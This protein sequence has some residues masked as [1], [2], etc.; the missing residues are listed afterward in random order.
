[1][2]ASPSFAQSSTNPGPAP[3]VTESMSSTIGQWA[4]Y[5]MTTRDGEVKF[6]TQKI[7]GEEDGALFVDRP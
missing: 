1:M 2:L 3:N 5:K 6:L 7:V 4:Q